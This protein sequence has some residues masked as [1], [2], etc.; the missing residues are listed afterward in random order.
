MSTLKIFTYISYFLF[1]LLTLYNIICLREDY[2][3]GGFGCYII[4]YFYHTAIYE[5]LFYILLYII[6]TYSPF[7]SCKSHMLD[8]HLYANDKEIYEAFTEPLYSSYKRMHVKHQ[9]CFRHNN[10][11]DCE[12]VKA[13][14]GVKTDM[15]FV[16][17]K[18]QL[19]RH[20]SHIGNDTKIV[21]EEM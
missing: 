10:L 4:A 14:I 1:L 13:K 3:I 6:Y 15:L 2:I 9:L 21:G 17:T 7:D 20:L 18:Q 19:T 12:H 11:D 16:G 8:F 5:I